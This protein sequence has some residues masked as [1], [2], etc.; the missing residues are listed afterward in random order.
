MIIILKV[1]FKNCCFLRLLGQILVFAWSP[2]GKERLISWS[3]YVLLRMFFAAYQISRTLVPSLS[4]VQIKSKN[5]WSDYN[6]KHMEHSDKLCRP[7]ERHAEWALRRAQGLPVGK[8]HR[9]LLAFQCFGGPAGQKAGWLFLNWEN[10]IRRFEFLWAPEGPPRSQRIL[11]MH[12]HMHMLL[13]KNIW[14]DVWIQL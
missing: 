11:Y 3:T 10:G 1:I 14:R 4:F 8:N 12:I 6:P 5:D 7:S 2:E 13:Y 9:T